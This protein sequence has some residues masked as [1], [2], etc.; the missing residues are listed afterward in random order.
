MD[1]SNGTTPP[2]LQPTTLDDPPM[3]ESIISVPLL[4]TGTDDDIPME[5]TIETM[6]PL[7]VPTLDDPPQ[8]Q[9]KKQRNKF[10]QG[11]IAKKT[12]TE[13]AKERLRT[14]KQSVH[15]TKQEAFHKMIT[16]S[17]RR[18]TED[19]LPNFREQMCVFIEHI[20][21]KECLN[22]KNKEETEC[23]CLLE[24]FSKESNKGIVADLVCAHYN[25]DFDVRNMVLIEKVKSI[26]EQIIQKQQKSKR[27]NNVYFKG[28]IFRLNIGT[29]ND[30]SSQDIIYL[31][32]HSFQLLFGIGKD[33]IDT[34]KKNALP[35][36]ASLMD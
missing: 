2:P 21:D 33:K 26:T 3:E 14:N 8:S 29:G 4:P 7:L 9:S 20:K 28:R 22:T 10:P 23:R 15:P 1:E 30:V 25:L 6:S 16:V 11:N 24:L 18:V 17:K 36:A 34:L 12:A 27:K 13:A 31:C 35:I 5:E 32:R 19:V